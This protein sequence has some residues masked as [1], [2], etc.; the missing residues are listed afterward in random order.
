M[1]IELYC[2]V[3]LLMLPLHFLSFLF[4]TFCSVLFIPRI[5]LALWWLEG[6]VVRCVSGPSSRGL[7]KAHMLLLVDYYTSF[8]LSRWATR[9]LKNAGVY[10]S[11]GGVSGGRVH[12]HVGTGITL[13]QSLHTPK[14]CVIACNLNSHH[15]WRV[16]MGSKY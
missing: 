6:R 9:P 14:K 2:H 13:T 1:F 4:C 3:L 11:L 16:L 7:T 8:F 5:V 10:T 15:L 12:A